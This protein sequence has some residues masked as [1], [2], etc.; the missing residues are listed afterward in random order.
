MHI[1]QYNSA[2]MKNLI[3]KAFQYILGNTV[4]GAPLTK[5]NPK[6]Y[7]LDLFKTGSSSKQSTNWGRKLIGSDDGIHRVSRVFNDQANGFIINIAVRRSTRWT[8]AGYNFENTFFM[9][10]VVTDNNLVTDRH[11]DTS[12]YVY[13]FDTPKVDY[14][15]NQTT[16]EEYITRVLPESYNQTA[17]AVTKWVDRRSAMFRKLVG[18]ADRYI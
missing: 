6:G 13:E 7:D 2:G 5:M 1:H 4:L 18:E 3:P 16:F 14:D 15:P 12:L 9:R 11:T 10:M 8:N 17:P